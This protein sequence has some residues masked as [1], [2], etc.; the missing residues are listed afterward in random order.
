MVQTI[1][2][3]TYVVEC[4]WP[5]VHQE[6]VQEAAG[7]LKRS[8]EELTLRGQRVQFTGSIFVPTDEVIFYLLE[9]GSSEAVRTTCQLAGLRFD[10]VLPCV[11]SNEVEDELD[12]AY[13]TSI[14]RGM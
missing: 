6:Q 5:D 4:F 13:W 2:K 9:G 10:R 14:S 3:T 7:R 8:A 12:L 1:G 11:L